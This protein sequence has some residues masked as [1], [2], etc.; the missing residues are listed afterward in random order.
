MNNIDIR[1]LL[2]HILHSPRVILQT[3]D[4]ELLVDLLLEAEG[5]QRDLLVREEVLDISVG[6]LPL[7]LTVGLEQ[8]ALL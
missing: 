2:A 6:F 5:Q 4:Y 1:T 3:F 8:D 7:L